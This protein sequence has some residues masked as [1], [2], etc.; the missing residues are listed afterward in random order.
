MSPRN[1]E[2]LE[3]VII[4]VASAAILAALAL[5]VSVILE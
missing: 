5:L 4:A 1:K 3:T 2:I